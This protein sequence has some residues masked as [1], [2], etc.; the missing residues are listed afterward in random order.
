MKCLKMDWITIKTTLHK[1]ISEVVHPLFVAGSK[2]EEEEIR[3]E[4]ICI[5]VDIKKD[6]LQDSL[7][8][9]LRIGAASSVESPRERMKPSHV[10]IK[11]LQLVKGLLLGSA[12]K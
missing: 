4:D 2:G 12:I 6:Q 7:T 5:L 3:N 10:I 11:E 9:R 8:G 1:R